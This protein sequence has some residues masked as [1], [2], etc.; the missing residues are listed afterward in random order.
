[1]DLSKRCDSSHS[2][3]FCLRHLTIICINICPHKCYSN[4]RNMSQR[5]VGARLCI[6]GRPAEEGRTP[7]LFK[8]LVHQ[9]E[10]QLLFFLFTSQ[11]L[12]SLCFS[13][14]FISFLFLS[15]A[16]K[17]NF[18]LQIY[19]DNKC[20]AACCC[21]LRHLRVRHLCVC[22]QQG[23]FITC[24]APRGEDGLTLTELQRSG[25]RPVSRHPLTAMCP[26]PISPP[27]RQSPCHSAG[28]CPCAGTNPSASGRD[29]EE[30]WSVRRLL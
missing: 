12:F 23:H 14:V 10:K 29:R 6:F 22:V 9:V 25:D 27:Q 20:P 24:E 7:K 26:P 17:L 19:K 13:F 18:F 4:R 2:H 30:Q 15:C 21:Q 16:A 28:K 11:T 5:T 1:M 8:N 3:C